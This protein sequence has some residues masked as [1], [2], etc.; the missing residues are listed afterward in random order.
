MG[1]TSVVT[2]PHAA[3]QMMIVMDLHVNVSL[4]IRSSKLIAVIFSIFSHHS[5]CCKINCIIRLPWHR[6]MYWINR[7]EMCSKHRLHK[8]WW[9]HDLCLQTRIYRQPTYAD[10]VFQLHKFINLFSIVAECSDLD[11]CQD[12]ST[13][14][15]DEYCIN[16]EPEDGM[17]WCKSSYGDSTVAVFG[18]ETY[19][20]ELSVLREYPLSRCDSYVQDTW[21]E[22][23]HMEVAVVGN[24]MLA[25]GGCIN[26]QGCSG[27]S[28]NI[29]L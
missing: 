14:N 18:G 23:K 4:D 7:R 15:E 22:Y 10:E 17:F 3:T 21:S 11:E 5:L 28:R 13:C 25:C 27:I 1:H 19:S 29:A 9:F 16:L 20:K 8:H 2:M 6:W 12:P 24:L 26:G